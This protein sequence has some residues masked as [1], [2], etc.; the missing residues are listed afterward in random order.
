M[1]YVQLAHVAPDL[2]QQFDGGLELSEYKRHRPAI[3][4]LHRPRGIGPGPN[5]V[6]PGAAYPTGGPF[7]IGA[8][9]YRDVAEVR[10]YSRSGLG[11]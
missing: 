10:P 8:W 7:I 6:G 3:Q 2:E 1:P 11:A 4:P 9:F 5:S